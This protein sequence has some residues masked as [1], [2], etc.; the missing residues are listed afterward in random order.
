M[1]C[2]I[3]SLG[4]G[5]AG[6]HITNELSKLT[7]VTLHAIGNVEPELYSLVRHLDWRMKPLNRDS[8]SVKIWHQ[9]DLCSHVGTGLHVGWPIFEL[10]RFNDEELKSLL[11]CD[12]LIVCSEWAKSI[13]RDRVGM[14]CSVVPLGFDPSVFYSKEHKK[15]YNA[16]YKFFTAGKWEYRKGHD[17]LLQ[18]FEAAFTAKDDVELHL[19]CNN[20]FPQVDSR[21]WER[22]YRSSKLSEKIQL[23]ERQ[24]TQDGVANLM[25]S[26]DCGVFLSRAEGF[27]LELLECMAC[28]LDTIFTYHTGHTQFAI[29]RAIETDK[30]EKAEDGVWFNGQG[31]WLQFDEDCLDQTV[32]HMREAYKERKHGVDQLDRAKQFTWKN[33]AEKLLLTLS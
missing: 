12:K 13:I 29:G 24:S 22:Y 15:D 17:V 7:D 20:P 26:M 16:P 21:A 6:F 28:G 18:A 8:P 1:N 10:D 9:N 27:N 11:H 14:E 4:Y 32:E 23:V 31:N 25:R 19:L 3:N 30:R 2:P 5:I 33:S